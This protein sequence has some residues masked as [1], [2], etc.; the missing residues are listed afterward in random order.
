MPF[1]QHITNIKNKCTARLNALK[2]LAHTTF[3]HNKETTTTVYKQ[4]I[5][6][7]MEYASPAWA[8][9]LSG[10][11]LNTL[12]TLQNK[13]L[14]TITGCTSTT[15]TDH[16][17]QETKV[18]KIKDHLDLRGTQ[19]LATAST[20]P[21]HPLHYMAEHPH[22]PRNI[23]TTPSH[24]YTQI[25]SSLPPRS[26]QTGIKKHIHTH[27]THRSIVTLKD[28]TLL[29]A[30]PPDIHPSETSLPREDRVHL[31][32]LRC[33]HHPALLSYQKRLDDSIVEDCPG[34]NT[35]PH[36]IKHIMEDCTAHNHTRQQH[37]IH[38]LRDMWE[39]P[40]QAIA[41]LR[42]SGLFG[43]AA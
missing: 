8:A 31:A 30:R 26:P 3:G 41:F 6:S 16:I 43:Q 9:N 35:A 5:R 39:S 20:N 32:R 10:T 25:L 12:Q 13:A 1:K 2:S 22:M 17:H 28:N 15:P 37:N 7:V 38:S 33:G 19:I 4:F 14:K 21:Q 36:N 18:L 23:K 24:R 29:R 11:H 40:V 42:D 34:C 27:I